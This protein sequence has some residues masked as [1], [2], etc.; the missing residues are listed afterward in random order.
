MNKEF[1]KKL[2]NKFGNDGQILKCV[3]ELSEL[4]E[5]L[6]HVLTRKEFNNQNYERANI[7]IEMCDVLMTFE[8]L[9]I[10]YSISE[11]EIQNYIKYKETVKQNEIFGEDI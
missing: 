5:P 9:K 8:S 10:I 7:I 4:I 11:E 2:V 3:E 6:V 1:Y